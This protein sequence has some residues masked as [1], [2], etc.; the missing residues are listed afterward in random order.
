MGRERERKNVA[1][2]NKN[3]RAYFR[4]EGSQVQGTI[5]FLMGGKKEIFLQNTFFWIPPLPPLLSNP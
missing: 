3:E 2:Q 5:L 4:N 1:G